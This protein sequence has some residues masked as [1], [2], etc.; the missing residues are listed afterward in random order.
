MPT[1]K[2]KKRKVVEFTV[3][4]IEREEESSK[5]Q[6]G[7]GGRRVLVQPDPPAQIV[8]ITEEKAEA[9]EAIGWGV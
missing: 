1:G 4:Q 5:H 9:K 8:G 7:S 6:T 2:K 3:L